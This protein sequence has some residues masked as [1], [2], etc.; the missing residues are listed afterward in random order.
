MRLVETPTAVIEMNG[1]VGGK[2]PGRDELSMD[3]Y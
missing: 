2:S 1:G 3:L